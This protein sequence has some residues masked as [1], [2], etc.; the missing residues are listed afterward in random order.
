[1]A[2]LA[3]HPCPCTHPELP[4][5]EYVTKENPAAS[6]GKRLCTVYK[7]FFEFNCSVS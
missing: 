7:V 5:F 2:E 3:D 4:Q 1:M 6:R